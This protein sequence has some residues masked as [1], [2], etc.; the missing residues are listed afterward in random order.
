MTNNHISVT[1]RIVVS[2]QGHQW[3][4]ALGYVQAIDSKQ[5]TLLLDR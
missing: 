1:N 3:G 4:V 2:I 5:L